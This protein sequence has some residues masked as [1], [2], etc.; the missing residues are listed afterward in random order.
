MPEV[1]NVKNS[2]EEPWTP[3]TLWEKV[4]EFSIGDKVEI[5]LAPDKTVTAYVVR[6]FSHIVLFKK[7]N[8]VALTLSYFD[9]A[10][11]RLVEKSD[12]TVHD[13]Q[14]DRDAVLKT[15]EGYKIS[16]S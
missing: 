10:H 2:Q 11:A 5:D 8:G 16:E 14:M 3:K 1:D 4:H 7:T 13:E 15:L 9:A 6:F 12:F